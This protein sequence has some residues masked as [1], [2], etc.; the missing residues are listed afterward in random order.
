MRWKSA[1]IVARSGVRNDH[2]PVTAGKKGG[3]IDNRWQKR[4]KEEE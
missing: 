2:M 4:R 1:R 3:R